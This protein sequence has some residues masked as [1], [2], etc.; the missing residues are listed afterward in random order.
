MLLQLNLS[1][2]IPEV[3]RSRALVRDIRPTAEGGRRHAHSNEKKSIGV[4]KPDQTCLHP[5][6]TLFQRST[7]DPLVEVAHAISQDFR[8]ALDNIDLCP[9]TLLAF[10]RAFALGRELARNGLAHHYGLEPL[11]A[12]GECFRGTRAHMKCA[13]VAF[14]ERSV[15][16]EPALLV[17]KVRDSC[18]PRSHQGPLR[19]RLTPGYSL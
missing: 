14:T 13:T 15:A 3:Q 8:R 11:S 2:A 18:G 19:S 7:L 9:L 1:H 6:A 17:D 10:L 5:I 4:T 16:M 12:D